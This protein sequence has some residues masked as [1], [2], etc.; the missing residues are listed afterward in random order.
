MTPATRALMREAVASVPVDAFDARNNRVRL[1]LLF[2]L[3]SPDF[4]L[5]R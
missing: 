1:A 5:Q 3:A 4:I 2:A